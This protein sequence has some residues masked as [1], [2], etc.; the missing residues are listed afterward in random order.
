MRFSEEENR[1]E[2]DI[3]IHQ[4]ISV[5]KK[6]FSHKF[7]VRVGGVGVSVSINDHA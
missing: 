1:K 2:K 4:I 7:G 3:I 5:I 6:E